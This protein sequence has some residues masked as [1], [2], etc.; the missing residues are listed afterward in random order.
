MKTSSGLLRSAS[1]P[2]VQR[3]R[4][5]L[6]R[7]EPAADG[8]CAVEG[9]HLVAEALRSPGVE[10]VS[11]LAAE[12][13]KNKLGKLA[14]G[15]NG[16]LPC[17]LTTDRVFRSLA[18]TE[19]PQGIAALV[20]L[21]RWR[22]EECLAADSALVAVLAGLQ[23]PG[24]LGTILR[25][26]EAFG[27]TTC[28]LTPGSVSPF[29]NKAVRASAG[30]LFRVPVFPKVSFEK[31]AEECR[32]ARL[33]RI[34]LTPHEGTPLEELDLRAPV[35]FFLGGEAKGLKP[36]AL[37]KMDE[38]ARIPLPGAVESLNAA[39]AASL[40]FYETARQRRARV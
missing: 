14:A 19:T 33:K 10:V 24:N 20:R 30:S 6:R 11:V 35:A 22:L 5:A 2:L 27:G 9:E 1:N 7:G 18:Q 17:S 15:L 23:D 25:A 12:S 36:G 31:S 21:P 40:A 16:S 39:V 28:L 34:G 8:C 29:N 3:Y 13:A 38:L 4:R 37:A 26:L 32:K